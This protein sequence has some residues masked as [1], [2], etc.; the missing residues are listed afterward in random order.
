MKTPRQTQNLYCSVR[1]MSQTNEWHHTP[2]I[3]PD[4]FSSTSAP[5]NIPI[6]AEEL[7]S[8]T[9]VGAPTNQAVLADNSFGSYIDFVE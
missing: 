3:L 6:V 8:V 2:S 1:V 7:N 4:R 5:S 9:M